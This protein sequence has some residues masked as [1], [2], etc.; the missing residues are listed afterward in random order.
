MLTAAPPTHTERV[1]AHDQMGAIWG[2]PV[3]PV[4]TYL[5]VQMKLGFALP[6]MISTTV[7]LVLVVI[8]VVLGGDVCSNVAY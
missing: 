2:A 7:F 3:A 6:M 4:L 5:A 8:A 1:T